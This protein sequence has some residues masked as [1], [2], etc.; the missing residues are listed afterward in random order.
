MKNEYFNSMKVRLIQPAEDVR[1]DSPEFQF[2]EGS[3]NTSVTS[4]PNAASSW[5]Q[6]HEGSINTKIYNDF[7]RNTQ[8]S[9][10]W[11]FD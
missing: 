7:Y 6:F 2:H 11:R 10:P 9:I 4:Q 1:T 3:I 5:F 8:I